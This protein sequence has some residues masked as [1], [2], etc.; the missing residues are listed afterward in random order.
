MK[1]WLILLLVL[2]PV[3][4]SAQLVPGNFIEIRDD[5]VFQG[6]AKI[7][8]CG[9][10]IACTVAGIT[11]TITGSGGSFAPIDATYWTGSANAT[12]TNEIN[13]GALGTGLVI[14]TAGTPSILAG[15]TC[16][17]NNFGIS[18]S[19][20]GVLGC[21]Q[22]LFSNISGS[23]TDGQVPNNITIDLATAATSL[24]ANGGNC[25]GNNFALGV[26]AAGVAECAQP[27]FSNLSGSATTG[28]IGNDQVT[29]AK[30][31]NVASSRFLGR[32]TAGAGDAEE[33]TGTQA[34][35]LL[36]TFTNVLK[37]LAPASG[38]G[39]TN[40]L[41]ADGTW[42]APPGG[43]P[44]SANVASVTIDFGASG[45]NH[46]KTV[47]T[48]QAWVTGTSVIVCSP[49]GFSTADRPDGAEDAAIEGLVVSVSERV[50]G[51]G[52]TLN[53]APIQGNAIG[54]YLIGC[55]GA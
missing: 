43:G 38:G 35:T 9:S 28:Q 51:T 12:L 18:M 2:L 5:T 37:G 25:V 31:Q 33:L 47:V 46:V 11:A 6:R 50:V 26:D 45:S 41:R 34:T 44:G 21:A 30:I 22:P 40:F 52:F 1:R 8:D 39:T 49:T 3:T 53:T 7:L 4:A 42:A 24:A 14:N 55:T 16:A 29:Y 17:A 19:A 20:S 23:V 15:N 48:G 54:K 32:I 13:L 27:D 36:D 10:G